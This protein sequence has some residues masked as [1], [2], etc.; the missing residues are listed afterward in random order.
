M[1]LPLAPR[2]LPTLHDIQ[3]KI[4]LNPSRLLSVENQVSPMV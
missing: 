4:A 1:F 3:Q 2:R